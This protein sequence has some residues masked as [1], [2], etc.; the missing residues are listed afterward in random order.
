MAVQLSR[1]PQK[2]LPVRPS[3]AERG[4]PLPAP[5]ASSPAPADAPDAI[6][7]RLSSTVDATLEATLSRTPQ[8]RSSVKL[9]TFRALLGR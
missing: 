8:V 7:P 6:V 2:P 4:V 1:A 9:E 5:G 3:E